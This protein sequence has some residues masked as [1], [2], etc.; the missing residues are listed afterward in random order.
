MAKSASRHH[1]YA[2]MASTIEEK[3]AMLVAGAAESGISGDG[4]SVWPYASRVKQR[5]GS[6]AAA[7][8]KSRIGGGVVMWRENRHHQRKQS[9]ASGVA[10]MAYRKQYFYGE[11]AGING[12]MANSNDMAAEKWRSVSLISAGGVKSWRIIWR[13]GV[14]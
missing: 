13:H 4:E 2:V 3:M 8:A 11:N 1:Q 14:A 10:A 5:H 7:Y 12:G 6:L 9:A